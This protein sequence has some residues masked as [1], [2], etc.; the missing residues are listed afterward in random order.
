MANYLGPKLSRLVRRR[1]YLA[2]EIVGREKRV[3]ELR[4]RLTAE[5]KA[6]QDAKDHLQALDVE[7]E[8][9]SAL[10]VA[11]IRPIRATPRT[12]DGKHGQFVRELIRLLKEANGPVDMENLV[13]PMALRFSIPFSTGEERKRAGYLV[14]RRLNKLREYGAVHRLPT[15]PGRRTGVW[16]W[17]AD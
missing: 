9:E 12:M 4:S 13:E 10:D 16:R 8:R 11:D 17:I 3:A 2:G 1:A 14:R 7:I 5:E 15:V 6:V